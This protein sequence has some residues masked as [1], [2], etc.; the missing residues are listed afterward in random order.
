[1]DLIFA[2]QIFDQLEHEKMCKIKAANF[3][4]KFIIAFK[5]AS[6]LLLF[7]VYHIR[8]L[9]TLIDVERELGSHLLGD[10]LHYFRESKHAN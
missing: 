2:N 10:D 1:M 3:T 8:M 9:I 7:T 6:S 4:A 5:I